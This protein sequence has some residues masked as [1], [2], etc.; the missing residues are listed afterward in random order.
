MH[1]RIPVKISKTEDSEDQ[2]RADPQSEV[3]PPAQSLQE[4]SE[5]VINTWNK[6]MYLKQLLELTAGGPKEPNLDQSFLIEAT[7]MV[8]AKAIKSIE[9]I[10]ALEAQ[11]IFW[12]QDGPTSLLDQINE[13]KQYFEGK[14]RVDMVVLGLYMDH[15]EGKR[16]LPRMERIKNI[17][18]S[19]G[20]E[21]LFQMP[22]SLQMTELNRKQVETRQSPMQSPE[23]I[24]QMSPSAEHI[25][26]H[27]SS[28]QG[29][30]KASPNLL[31]NSPAY[32][33]FV[34]RRL[35]YM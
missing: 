6:V 4:A 34:E 31:K 30:K 11:L 10:A 8:I 15:L 33:R 22:N 21:N 35:M 9:N 12:R 26:A 19:D 32:N 13:C 24:L 29:P 1:S 7:E 17:D 3:I 18:L 16:L 28:E 2:R 23:R 20:T 14:L 27:T 5:Q 25:V